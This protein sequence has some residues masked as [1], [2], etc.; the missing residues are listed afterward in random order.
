MARRSRASA[1]LFRA[2]AGSKW[3]IIALDLMARSLPIPRALH[4]CPRAAIAGLSG[5]LSLLAL[6]PAALA[7]PTE[8]PPPSPSA[9]PALT[10]PPA[11]V[12]ELAEGFVPFANDIP[13]MI[14]AGARLGGMHE[15]WARAGYMPTGDDRG[16]AFGCAGYRAT[17]RP[18]KV[19]RPVVGGLFAGLPATCGHDEMGKPVCADTPLFIV[20]ATG[21]V[22]LMLTPWLGLS[23]TVMLG[24]DSYP[25]PFGM[26]EISQ[27][28]ALPLPYE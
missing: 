4:R 10:A 9:E 22:R 11:I 23:A 6:A 21:G 3:A 25:N 2:P 20:A 26:I 12:F 18:A 15:I 27:T 7:E 24:V 16:H 17:F 1:F 19:A 8:S 13:L 28:F 14:G 5:A